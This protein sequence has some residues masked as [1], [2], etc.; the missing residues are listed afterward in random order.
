MSYQPLD[1]MPTLHGDSYWLAE[2]QTGLL[3]T[4]YRSEPNPDPVRIFEGTP[5]AAQASQ[6]P[7]L[8][9]LSP[10][11]TFIDTLRQT[12]RALR[13]LLLATTAP[14]TGLLI[15]LQSLLQARFSQRRKAL[16]RFYD[17][18][19]ASYLL[20]TCEGTLEKRWLGP[21]EQIA[22]FG[23]T[24]SDEMA[25]RQRWHL[26]TRTE[27]ANNLPHEAPLALSDSQLQRL[28]DQ[29]YEH[30]A[31]R[32]L[33]SHSGYSMAGLVTE[34]RAGI[35]LGYKDEDSLSAWLGRSDITQGEQHA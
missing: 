33:Q 30:F 26:L 31:W 8:F 15:Q 17:P 1:Y 35:A 5:F 34:I 10:D 18:R 21:I 13:G 27:T 29:G 16:L 28:V 22:W 14:H 4:L 11:G 12:P 19:V 7:V 23:G 3:E 9:K 24:W 2:P 25:G 20:P 32:W 6:S